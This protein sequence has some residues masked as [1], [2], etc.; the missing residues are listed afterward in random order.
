MQIEQTCDNKAAVE[1]VQNDLY[2]Q[3]Q[4]LAPEADILLAC[5]KRRKE[6]DIDFEIEWVKGHQDDNTKE[7]DL[8]DEA[9]LNIEMDDDAKQKRISGEVVYEKPYEGSGAMLIIN[10][11]WVTNKYAK[12]T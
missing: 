3:N 8:T 9:R 5:Q 7:E 2:S 10:N 6:S 1:G 12:H 11:Q 4:M